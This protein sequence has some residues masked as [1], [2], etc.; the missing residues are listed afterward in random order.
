MTRPSRPY[1]GDGSKSGLAFLQQGGREQGRGGCGGQAGQVEP[2]G[3]GA[4]GGE[5]DANTTSG[6]SGDSASQASPRKNRAGDSHCYN[7]GKTDH[8]AY[9]CPDLTAEQQAQ[10]YMHIEADPDGG[11]MQEEGHQLLN[12][13]FLQGDAL[14]DNRA[15]DAPPSQRSRWTGT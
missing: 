9:E 14:P 2:T 10:L 12:V 1:R 5:G 4:G 3:A 11:D 8:W 13:S 6:A 7:C 15:T